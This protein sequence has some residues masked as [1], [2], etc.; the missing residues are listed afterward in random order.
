MGIIMPGA[1]KPMSQTLNGLRHRFDIA[2]LVIGCALDIRD[3]YRKGVTKLA[4]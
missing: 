4:G 3:I 1:F 2:S